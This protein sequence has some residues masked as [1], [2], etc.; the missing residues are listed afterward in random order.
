MVEKAAKIFTLLCEAGPDLDIDKLA[1]EFKV[2]SHYS[3]VKE[4]FKN[5]E[6]VNIPVCLVKNGSINNIMISLSDAQNGN[7][8]INILDDYYKKNKTDVKFNIEY[9]RLLETMFIHRQHYPDYYFDIMNNIYKDNI[10]N[11]EIARIY[12]RSLEHGFFKTS[13]FPFYYGELDKTF[14]RFES[15][16]IIANYYVKSID[17]LIRQKEKLSLLDW[18]VKK[19]EEIYSIHKSIS[20]YYSDALLK[21]LVN[22][23]SAEIK[24]RVLNKLF[25]VSNENKSDLALAWNYAEGYI[26]YISYDLENYQKEKF[27]INNY[28]SN[29]IYKTMEISFPRNYLVINYDEEFDDDEGSSFH[30]ALEVYIYKPNDIISIN[31][32]LRDKNIRKVDMN[33]LTPEDKLF[34]EKLSTNNVKEL[35]LYL[36]HIYDSK[37]KDKDPFDF[38][39]IIENIPCIYSRWSR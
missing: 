16:E 28:A 39:N 15:D 1:D 4:H 27:V 25:D 20:K 21:V 38:V 18:D 22:E 12:A 2:Y 31:K 5:I 35:F 34:F 3:E 19:L 32:Q 37:N 6:L 11:I 14:A 24:Y 13:K 23:R 10:N 17:V 26:N 29:R 36:L 33:N 7:K 30:E 9:T 8:I